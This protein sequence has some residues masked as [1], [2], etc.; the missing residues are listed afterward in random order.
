MRCG[1]PEHQLG[2]KCAVKNAKVQGMPQTRTLP[3]G[4]PIQEKGQES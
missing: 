2:Q 1:K 4:M 3:Q